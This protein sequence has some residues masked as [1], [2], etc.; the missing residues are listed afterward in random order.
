M[1]L[2]VVSFQV[3]M[4]LYSPCYTLN[5]VLGAQRAK[6]KT[7]LTILDRRLWIGISI[8]MWLVKQQW[9]PVESTMEES[10]G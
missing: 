10:T 9:I 5:Q 1:S 8:E 4:E 6:P 7:T 3:R 2:S